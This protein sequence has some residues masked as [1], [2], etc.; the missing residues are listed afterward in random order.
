MDQDNITRGWKTSVFKGF[1][2]LVKPL[3]GTGIGKIPPIGAIYRY[4]YRKLAINELI[5]SVYGNKLIIRTSY[6]D[7]VSNEVLYHGTYEKYETKLFEQ[8]INEGMTII[9]IGA[10]VGYYALLAARL[11]GSK[12][13]I[14][15][16]E[17][18][19]ENYN[20]LLRNIKLNGYGNVVAIKKAVSNHTGKTDLF[21]NKETGAHCF[22]P[23]R[24][25][26]V[27]KTTVETISLDEYFKDRRYPIDIIKIDVEGSELAVI[28]G[29]QNVIKD[30][31]NLKIF[32]EFWPWGLQKSGFPPRAYWD[33]LVDSG[34]KYIYLINEREQR[35]EPTDFASVMRHCED[36]SRAKLPSANLLCTKVPL[37]LKV[38]ED[39]K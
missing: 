32:S 25:G 36:T 19:S 2:L 3:W 20:L 14:Y 28:M 11:V 24:E 35:L 1:I 30:N 22:L 15:A 34:F 5:M 33:K 13:K 26:I 21:L 16:F 29:M 27:G 10:N 4:L 18:E 23:E 17:P 37:S 39:T 8:Y 38:T 7:G 9:D 6:L 12:G 31:D